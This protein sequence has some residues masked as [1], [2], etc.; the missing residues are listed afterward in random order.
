MTL[1]AYLLLLPA[2]LIIAVTALV[3]ANDIGWKRK[4]GH[5]HV[6]RIGFVLVGGAA[7]GYMLK[8]WWFSGIYPS[9]YSVVLAWGVALTWITTPGQPPW[10]RYVSGE[11]KNDN[12]P[13]SR[14]S[15]D[16]PA[17]PTE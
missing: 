9:W 11:Y 14:R 17:P 6:R 12:V 15:T 2:L 8:P 5:W 7:V 4:G 16:Q 13:P 10:W 3:R 1:F